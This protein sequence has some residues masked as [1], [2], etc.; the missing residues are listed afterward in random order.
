MILFFFHLFIQSLT[1]TNNIQ[2]KQ[3]QTYSIQHTTCDKQKQKV[4]IQIVYTMKQTAHRV[5]LTI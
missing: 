4:K 2:H 1:Q 3:T 5:T